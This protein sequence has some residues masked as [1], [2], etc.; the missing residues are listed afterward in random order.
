ML[1]AQQ[2][3]YL[4]QVTVIEGRHLTA[5]GDDGLANP[6]CKIRIGKSNIQSSEV[7]YESLTPVW[8]Q[9]FTFPNLMLSEQ[10][11]Q[12]GELMFELYSKN[13]FVGNS[14]I[15]C[16]SV[17]LSTLYKNANHEYYNVWL[18]LSNPE[19]PEES[20]GY[21]L[22]DCFIVRAGDRP[23][24][25]SINDA[26]NQDVG[27]EDEDLNLDNMKFDELKAYQEKQQ[28]IIILGKPTVARK[29]FQLSCYIIKCENLSSFEGLL[30]KV[31]P[32][33]FI[34]VRTAG[35]VQTTK[36]IGSNSSPNFNQKILFPT[37]LPFLNDKII[38]RI[39]HGVPGASEEF[40]GN[41]PEF[42]TPN[43]VFNISK[44]LSMGGRMAAIWVNIYCIQPWERNKGLFSAKKK[45]P[46]MGT[47]FMGRIL[48]SF[49]LLPNPTPFFGVLPCNTMGVR[50]LFIYIN[51][52]FLGPGF[53]SI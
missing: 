33:A 25:R 4:V 27:E 11:F 12:T 34:S 44:L 6:F 37:Y 38:M 42:S 46:S 5:K 32:S 29:A 8:N 51:N 30:G 2:T 23:P 10:E 50:F 20:Q 43:D 21:L 18:T 31:K 17:G 7:V 40:I 22:I 19:Y 35:L 9:S 52:I 47:Y 1:I 53:T 26:F 36:T 45:H 41:I 28:G 15:G 16:Y 39:W 13:N 48:V 14:L 3:E 49:T 24:V